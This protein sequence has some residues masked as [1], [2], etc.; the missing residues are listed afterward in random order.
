M[1][2]FAKIENSVVVEI[3][4]VPDQFSDFGEQYLSEILGIGGK[5]IETPRPNSTLAVIGGNYSEQEDAFIPPK[6]DGNKWILNE[7]YQWVKETFFVSDPG[8][9]PLPPPNF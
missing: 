2:T 8:L 4:V 1:S 3:L 7:E 5:W 6:P 9:P